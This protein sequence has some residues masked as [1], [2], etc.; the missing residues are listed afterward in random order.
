MNIKATAILLFIGLVCN[1]I[2]TNAMTFENDSLEITFPGD[3]ITINNI[4]W[5][6]CPKVQN[7]RFFNVS[8]NGVVILWD[9]LESDQI[10]Y[11]IQIVDSQNNVLESQYVN[12]CSFFYELPNISE[13]YRAEIR[14]HC[15]SDNNLKS[16]QSSWS[17]SVISLKSS[18]L[19]S[20]CSDFLS[21][22]DQEQLNGNLTISLNNVPNG[23]S[24]SVTVCV[25]SDCQ[26]ISNLGTSDAVFQGAY[27]PGDI[28]F[29]NIS[30]NTSSGTVN[31]D[32]YEQLASSCQW[33]MGTSIFA[34]ITGQ[35][36]TATLEIQ[37]KQIF[38]N[39]CSADMDISVI[40]PVGSE[41][42]S[43][44]RGTTNVPFGQSIFYSYS[45]CG[46]YTI[47]IVQGWC[48]CKIPIDVPCGP[49]VGPPIEC[50]DYNGN[51]LQVFTVSTDCSADP[52]TGT[53]N[54][55]EAGPNQC[56]TRA[57]NGVTVQLEDSNGQLISEDYYVHI[58]GDIYDSVTI[59]GVG[60]YTFRIM[61]S[62]S[63]S[64]PGYGYPCEH[65][66]EFECPGG[67]DPE[68]CIVPPECDDLSYNIFYSGYG[69]ENLGADS[70]CLID[71]STGYDMDMNISFTNNGFVEHANTDSNSGLVAIPS[72]SEVNMSYTL[73]WKDENDEVHTVDC[74]EEFVMDCADT[75]PTIINPGLCDLVEFSQ[76]GRCNLQWSAPDSIN[77]FMTG[78]TNGS[79]VIETG[80]NG[81]DSLN[82]MGYITEAEFYISY[83][84]SNG[85][86]EIAYCTQE[87]DPCADDP[88]GDE[89]DEDENLCENV[90][91]ELDT[92][93]YLPFYN[94]SWVV[95]EVDNIE[96]IYTING[97]INTSTSQSGANLITPG[98]IIE[99]E[100]TLSNGGV[101]SECS[102]RIKTTAHEEEE[103]NEET[104]CNF[105]S[106][107]TAEIGNNEL[108][109]LTI[110]GG[111]E[112][113]IQG[114]LSDMGVTLE[115][116]EQHLSQLQSI[117]IGINYTN[118]ANPNGET[119]YFDLYDNPSENSNG[120]TSYYFDPISWTYTVEG[121][122]TIGIEGTFDLY[123]EDVEGNDYECG[124]YDL[125][126]DELEEEE[127]ED[128]EIDLDCGDTPEENYDPSLPIF[129][130]DVNDLVGRVVTVRGFPIII[131][132]IDGPFPSSG[133]AIAA[134]PFESVEVLISYTDLEVNEGPG[135]GEPMQ[136]T[137]GNITVESDDPANYPNFQIPNVPINIGGDICV[138]PPPPPGTDGNG[139]NT[140]T[141]L[142]NYGFNPETGEHDET[143]EPWDTN[144]FDINGN[145]VFDEPP[146]NEDG[147]PNLLDPSTF[148]NPYDPTGCSRDGIDSTG[149]PC[150]PGGGDDDITEFINDNEED[151]KNDIDSLLKE[152]IVEIEAEKSA[153]NCNQYRSIIDTKITNLGYNREFI[154]G[155]GDKYYNQ[156]LS[157]EFESAPK[158]FQ[159]DIEGRNAET[160]ELEDNHVAL[161]DCD[162]RELEIDEII[163][164]I[165]N[166]CNDPENE[167]VYN[168]I[169]GLI[170]AW[171]TIE[172]AQYFSDPV[173]FLEWLEQEI[174]NYFND[175]VDAGIGFTDPAIQV[176]PELKDI[177][178]FRN[179]NSPYSSV[180][181][182]E[183]IYLTGSELEAASFNFMQGEQFIN[184]VHRAYFLRAL[185]EVSASAD[186]GNVLKLPI[187]VEKQV[188]SFVYKIYLDNIT[189]G[190]GQ[191]ATL[192]AYFILED[193]ESGK[194][195]V[196]SGTSIPFAPGGLSGGTES[197]LTLLTDIELRLNNA[198]MLILR[199]TE[200][201]YVQWSCE[202]FDEMGI[203]LAIEFCR[204]FIVPLEAD[205][206]PKPDPE[207][208]RLE[209]STVIT[210]WL[211]FTFTLNS[212]GPFAM[213]K[214][215]DIKFDFSNIVVDMSSD[216]GGGIMPL[217]GY[218]S[219]YLEGTALTDAWKG[220]Y[221]ESLTVVLPNQF[222][223]GGSAITVDAN[224]I[225]IDGS[226]VTG[227]TTVSNEPILDEEEGNI[228]GWPLGITS[229]GLTV[230][231]NHVAGID[232]G[233]LVNVP[234]MEEYMEYDATIF[235]GNR[236][237]FTISPLEEVTINMFL[238]E[239]TIDPNSSISITYDNEEFVALADLSG[240]IEVTG[241]NS[242]SNLNIEVPKVTF[243]NLQ[244]SN[245]SPYFSPGTWAIDNDI[246]AGFKGFN[247]TLSN[248]GM[249]KP[250]TS[251]EEAGVGFDLDLSLSDKVT[252]LD[253]QGRMGIVG[254]LEWEGDRQ[255]WVYDRLDPSAFC[256]NTSFP[257][258]EY[259][260]ACVEW[261]PQGSQPDPV[262]GE[263]FRGSAEVQFKGFDLGISAV[264]QFGKVNDYKY[265]FVDAMGTFSPGIAVGP[266]SLNGFGGGISHHMRNTFNPGNVDFDSP[267]GTGDGIGE[268]FSGITYTPDQSLGLGLRAS[269]LF[270]LAGKEELF[271]GTV[272]FGMTFNSSGSGGGLA[273]MYLKGL[274]KF[275][276][277]P[278]NNVG[279]LNNLPGDIENGSNTKPGISAAL[280]GYVYFKYDFNAPSFDGDIGVFLDA[281]P[282]QGRNNGKLVDGK[283][284]FS[285]GSWYIQLGLPD[286]ASRCGATLDINILKLD[287][288]AYFVTG[289]S[290]PSIPPIPDRVREIAYTYK[291]FAGLGSAGPGLAFGAGFSAEIEA[292]IGGAI[293][294]FL[295]AEAGFDVMLKKYTDVTCGGS[296]IGLN[297]WYAAGQAY[298]ALKGGIKFF[299]IKVFEAGVATV[300]QARL[301]N[302]TFI[303]GTVGVEFKLLFKK[304]KK[305]IT[306]NLGDDCTFQ[307]SNPAAALGMDVISYFDPGD[308]TEG[309]VPDTKP[310][311]YM[312]APVET[313]F[314]LVDFEG[315]SHEYIIKKPKADQVILT[316]S[317]G[318]EIPTTSYILSDKSEIEIDP[319][320]MFPSNDTLTLEVTVD[321]WKNGSYL[322]S[323]TKSVTF[324]TTEGFTE[325]PESNVVSSYPQN[326]MY[327][328]FK[329]EHTECYIELDLGQP[330]LFYD[331]PDDMHQAFLLTSGSGENTNIEYEYD[332]YTNRVNFT[333]DPSL[334]SNGELYK[335]Q[336]LR[337]EDISFSSGSSSAG[338][339]S[340]A[341]AQVPFAQSI[342][343]GSYQG[344]KHQVLFK[345]FFRA[346]EYNTFAEKINVIN[347]LADDVQT[348]THRGTKIYKHLDGIEPFAV[349]ENIITSY[350]Q[351]TTSFW[352][353]RNYGTMY[354]VL[355][356]DV[357]TCDGIYPFG[358]SD[359][360]R[361]NSVYI[362]KPDNLE[363][364]AS[365]FRSGTI[366]TGTSQVEFRYSH[367]IRDD[368]S[369]STL[370]ISVCERILDEF[371]G[372]G[373]FDEPFGGGANGTTNHVRET[374]LNN[375]IGE[376][377]RDL[378]GKSF[379]EMPNGSYNTTIEYALPNGQVVSSRNISF[380]K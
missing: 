332:P 190:V 378:I 361:D 235:P 376:D 357:P 163:D 17:Q 304:F 312:N 217:D 176:I 178:D 9:K 244:V 336:L 343:G 295:W 303:S 44:N 335:L 105:F 76:G 18:R 43:G 22:I 56:G 224:D 104:L 77:V 212:P 213:A 35:G 167:D 36:P 286:Y 195:F 323:E 259:I 113:E 19:N 313:E 353:T 23:V 156:G 307:S 138:P 51:V 215:E 6:D 240:S 85:E 197:R 63:L 99:V 164:M 24:M 277:P 79:S 364:T 253:I 57:A 25:E 222:N 204:D 109:Y 90:V 157:K 20:L 181:S 265:F 145:Y 306:V 348:T 62:C 238:A 327:N 184:G 185:D 298:A 284:H 92:T 155:Q 120:G 83:V 363:I 296:S 147:T 192:D 274:G 243:S 32:G 293:E 246:S 153:L 255:K 242:G 344:P 272:E 158:E 33:Y 7:L 143:G 345:I 54:I 205:Y 305:S 173:A 317:N 111:D 207:R 359:H 53:I 310:V 40:P 60:L 116:I 144:G 55:S 216:A 97:D 227:Q 48:S 260:D 13:N 151:I 249:Y 49:P 203:D 379:I 232:I 132:T 16:L 245:K 171:G 292:G 196:M 266:L 126:V 267:A 34:K 122:S 261:Y 324:V 321:I 112:Q 377:V 257:G 218:E 319:L 282:L 182:T 198:A 152:L 125:P 129:D 42:T 86:L 254:K 10:E 114:A 115:T 179:S 96:V 1:S 101:D 12:T 100:M 349:D 186:G 328:Y 380:T 139:A 262:Y 61:N 234:I 270:T 142:D 287:L 67:P 4:T 3:T 210:E 170:Q 200:D 350:N 37:A 188:G 372:T 174:E 208:Y 347:A 45:G 211:E 58:D 264:A 88:D 136:A 315:N 329:E 241:N 365:V 273:E 154:L 206:T 140:A 52:P 119:A 29:S 2:F 161:Y 8:K 339:G 231:N 330:E 225:I 118:Q 368:L 68:C 160:K 70:I 338:S 346:S 369:G 214:Y 297:G 71:L 314:E 183:D 81:Q 375:L 127:E 94:F 66:I 177:F 280:A 285:P 131:C 271:N 148:P 46:T 320:Y 220:F 301:P 84:N 309:V 165:N 169:E 250:G 27:A 233:G 230:I 237:E 72:G 137:S 128:G 278:T 302:P 133:T 69:S 21:F 371:C 117:E 239:G 276:S 175:I 180:A 331:I 187:V 367:L 14:T 93:D 236:Y 373:A 162:V 91:I 110:A 294:G 351:A 95:Y 228:G 290:I 281:G 30:F 78:T 248:I 172:K 337:G 121:I 370:R 229:F 374:C 141:G 226:G 124:T 326:G 300:L 149:Q 5:P 194:S 168:H 106:L 82:V 65:V 291:P 41:I 279:L 268:S 146:L 322:I 15:Y 39:D 47:D 256:L 26:N 102:Y 289:S 107:M 201:T 123:I 299:G 189:W 366:P 356:K 31:C 341:Q 150:T 275:V 11:E 354:S 311:V 283:I 263:G 358:D 325:I 252:G 360:L 89:D 75:I 340:G 352:F 74:E 199:G 221:I 288:N 223:D 166:I 135:N 258:V 28:T 308:S 80:M 269:S 334:I 209:L 103:I 50:A 87:I 362:R 318:E 159:I 219:E 64:G 108:L 342:N 193:P 38:G 134:L 73:E 355:P 59:P 130:G 333:L 316:R 251:D 247:I 98:D 202:G 191:E